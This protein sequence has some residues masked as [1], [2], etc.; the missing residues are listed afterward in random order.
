M[1]QSI[2]PLPNPSMGGHWRGNSFKFG[3]FAVLLKAQIA[4]LFVVSGYAQAETVNGSPV[5]ESRLLV[6]P[7]AAT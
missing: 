7:S 5:E 4:S 3:L 6:T 2:R 1:F